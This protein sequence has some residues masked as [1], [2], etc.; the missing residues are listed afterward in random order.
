MKTVAISRS[1]KS[2]RAHNEVSAHI[3][4]TFHNR[5]GK[6]HFDFGRGAQRVYGALDGFECALSLASCLEQLCVAV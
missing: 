1:A 5:R 3:A 4:A 6:T 2:D